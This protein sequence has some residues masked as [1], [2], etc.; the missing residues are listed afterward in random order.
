MRAL[1]EETQPYRQLPQAP[2]RDALEQLRALS[3]TD[4]RSLGGHAG[5]GAGLET[6]DGIDENR[7]LE[8]ILL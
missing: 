6:E 5:S 2:T 8:S 4:K 1:I 7:R 3:N